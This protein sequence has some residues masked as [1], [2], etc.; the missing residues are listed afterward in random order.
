VKYLLFATLF[1]ASLVFG[2]SERGNITGV[3]TDASGAPLPGAPVTVANTDT[4]T[5]AH[6]S[7]TSTG[8]Y[9]VPNLPPGVY[10]V[11]VTAPGFKTFVVDRITMTAGA[12]LRADA[13]L[14][15]GQLN[16]SVEVTAQ[17]IQMQTDDAKI[18]NAVQNKLV[19]ELPLVVGGALRSP[20]DL[21]TTVPESKGSGN[22][23]SL[24]GGQA[25]SWGATLDGLSV[26]TN[27]SADATETAYMTPSVEAIT[28][29][30]VDT[31]GFKAEYGQAGGG[32][33]T[34]VSKSGTNDFH[35]TVYEFLRND[36]FDA[37]DFFAQTRSVYKQ[38]D[39]GASA[40]GP[41]ILPKL[42]NGRNRTFFFVSYE[43]FRNRQ[44]ANGTI[45]TVPTPE[46][47]SGDFSKWVNAQGRVLPIYD[48][49]ST[50]AQPG[51]GFTRTPFPNN[52]IPVSRFST[53]SNQILPF[54]QGVA[55]NR[56][57]IVPGTLG[58]VSNNYLTGGG[59]TESPTDK[60]SVKIDQNFG[61]NHRLNFFYNRTRYNS[62]PGPAGPAGL[63]E[64]LWNGSV[65][66]Y[67]S[68]LYRLSHDWTISP[69]MFNHF[70]IGG[71]TFSKNSYSP[72]SGQNW[73][74]KVCIPNA[75]DCNVNFPNISFTEFTQ[76]GSTAYNGTEQPSWS[77]K[78]DLSYIHGAHSMKYGYAFESQRA[79]GFGQ[80]NI[81]GQ[82]TF[83]FLET[84]VPGATSFTSGSSFASFLL[85]AA[86]SGATETIRYLPQTYAYHGFYAQDDWHVTKK[87]T[88]NLGLRY[89]FTQPPVAGDDQYSDFSPTT[90]NP[91]ANNYPGALIFAGDGPGRQGKR[92]LIPGWYGAWGPRF[93]LAYALNSKTTIR[94]GAARSFS[95]VTVVASSGH[96]AGFIG[97][98]AFTSSNQGVT[99]A[100]YW[101]QG[102]PPY[103]LPPQIDPSFANNS[104][105]DYWQGQN[106]T[107]APENDN[108]AFSIQREITPSTI[109]EADYT[110]VTGI[111][112]QSGTVN[113]NQ[114]PMATVNQLIQQY[115]TTQ[116]VN[117][118]NSN[119]T[120]ATAVSAGI[121]PPYANFTNPAVQR[122]RSVAQSL[123]PYP[124]YLNVDT[125]QSG[126][127]KSGH[128]TYHALVLKLNRRYSN[129]LTFQ[130]S[131]TFSKLLTD[132]D[133]YYANGGYAE[134]QGNRRLEKSIG[135]FDQTHVWKFNTVYELPF[136]KGRRWLTQGIGNQVLGGWRVSAVQ[137]Y[138]SGFPIG[139]TRNAPLPIFNGTNR[140]VITSY[141]WKTS[142]S[143]DFDPNAGR[144]LNAAAFPAQPANL[145]GNATR[146]NPL[147]RAFPSFNENVSLGKSFLFTERFRLDF[148]AEAFNLFNRVVFAAPSGNGLNLNNTA[149]GT[150]TSTANSPRQMQLALKLYW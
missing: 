125:S 76:W 114:V 88:L 58:W 126:G 27:R 118:L 117:I 10:R 5:A 78:N 123:R 143:G 130:W 41:V 144:Y 119:I 19:D 93:G 127:D 26:N 74:S 140:P 98:Y 21:V 43:G 48:P 14:Q 87:L 11:E 139:V 35:G 113:I 106:A 18:S 83:S 9:N 3:V 134:D 136:G 120:S 133:T 82:A 116:A 142:W 150:V 36:A 20:F 128:S 137:V 121:A 33:I 111:H 132:A 54:A 102:L 77:L 22:T 63:P 28:E 24:G 37:R 56:P 46:M 96:Y 67:D 146:F 47:Y 108:W 51:G 30:S 72:N 141:D 8:E 124:Q 104:N 6:V 50:V 115:G 39:F 75:V 80:Q 109:L 99:P 45:L 60:G 55:P 90:P 94:A 15:V 62:N 57:G 100:F 145:L 44:G 23:L 138:S 105:V 129:G 65:S 16:E 61:P 64:P 112:L 52:Q 12:T 4:N 107:R 84:A 86:D 7:T 17:A 131:Y 66:Q 89:E 1:S 42:Y 91:A 149:F 103:P 59:D 32:V 73:K 70:S 38:S 2:Q 81:A 69:Q 110:G 148:R 31:N 40:G 101:D 49:T 135:R 122:Q 92:S 71:N 68:S 13:Q 85:G 53:V 97:Q 95:R 147:V 25:A 29:F 34:F 79:N